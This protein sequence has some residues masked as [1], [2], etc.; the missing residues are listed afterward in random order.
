MENEKHLAHIEVT[1]DDILES[2]S[3]SKRNTG[4]MISGT[5]P[6]LLFAACSMV[7]SLADHIGVSTNTL[8]Q[9]LPIGCNAEKK[10]RTKEELVDLSSLRDLLG[11]ASD[12]T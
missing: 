8:L 5:A 10:S 1:I 7:N 3:Q 11:G 9:F 6:D 4:I 12:A 2:G